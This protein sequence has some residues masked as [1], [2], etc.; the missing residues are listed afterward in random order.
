MPDANV[1]RDVDLPHASLLDAPTNRRTFIG[2]AS[3]L[4]LAIPGL[5][6]ALAGCSPPASDE[7][8]QRRDSASSGAN[9]AQGTQQP[10][11]HNSDSQLD[12]SLLKGAKHGSS[13]ATAAST[14][15][16]QGT[17][18]HRFDPT[19]PALSTNGRTQLHWHVREAPVRISADTVVA[20]WTFEGDMPGPIVH[21]RVG[22]VVEFTLTND[23]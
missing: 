4:S 19:L 16:A 20:A 3:A 22:D 10:K 8:R 18:F 21:C 15:G 14:Q 23:V 13:S 17:V 7:V 12:T 11:I 9:A 2:R 5:G 1:P 6:A